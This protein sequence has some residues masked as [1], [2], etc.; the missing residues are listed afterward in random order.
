MIKHNSNVLE[1]KKKQ[2]QLTRF[3]GGLSTFS[4]SSDLGRN[5]LNLASI[6]SGLYPDQMKTHVKRCL[7]VFF[8]T[9]D[10]TMEYDRF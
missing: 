8:R 7:K 10:G 3:N 5:L 2:I 1:R 9:L 4:D 6:S